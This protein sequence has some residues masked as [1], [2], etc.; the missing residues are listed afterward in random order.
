MR[1]LRLSSTWQDEAGYFFNYYL[2]MAETPSFF[3]HWYTGG[4][5]KWE[6]LWTG[7]KM[8]YQF[9]EST[10]Y[11]WEL[12]LISEDM[13]KANSPNSNN[14]NTVHYY[15]ISAILSLASNH[16]EMESLADKH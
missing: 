3:P 10:Q 4:D 2:Y 7:R 13:R 6:N 9:R 14:S 8:R 12:Y 5:R 16:S 11:Y 15:A 1:G